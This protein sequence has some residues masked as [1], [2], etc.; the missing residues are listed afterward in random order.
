MINRFLTRIFFLILVAISISAT[1]ETQYVTD[2]LKVGLH[3][4][5]S[6]NSPI[7]KIITTGTPLEIIKVE[8]NVSF[9]KEPVGASGWIDN[10]YLVKQGLPATTKNAEARIKALEE[11]LSK[12][13]QQNPAGVNATLTQLQ[14][15][16]T[17]L[18]QQYKSEKVRTGEL[19]VELLELQKRRGD[20]GSND[21]LYEKIDQLSRQ[22]KQLE[23]QLAQ[24]LEGSGLEDW[25]ITLDDLIEDE[26]FNW[27][28][29]LIFLS[30][31]LMAGMVLGIYLMDVINRRRH[32]GFRV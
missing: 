23:V 18:E 15:E 29:L 28:N 30:I 14:N 31:A 4:N 11:S 24:I 10:S 12:A 13:K 20:G 32:G 8:N 17:D 26:P 19:Q 5:K 9:V 7:I 22:N 25:E 6:V 21:S 2:Q 3:T 16:N 1:A 27:R